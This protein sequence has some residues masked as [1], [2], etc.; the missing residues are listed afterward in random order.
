[1]NLENED[2]MQPEYD[3]RGGVRGKYLERYRRWTSI[4]SDS[5]ESVAGVIG[6]TT[7][8]GSQSSAKITTLVSYQVPH[9]SPQTR[10]GGLRMDT[11]GAHAGENSPRG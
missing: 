2:E 9:L 8:T 6:G 1:M 11:V 10:F 3:M 7:G 4:T 5:V